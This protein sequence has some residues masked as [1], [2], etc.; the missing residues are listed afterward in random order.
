MKK[1]AGILLYRFVKKELQF[2]LVHPG[3][4]FWKNKDAGAW[5][6][7]KGEYEEDE[8]P[9]EAARREFREETGVVVD[10]HFIELRTARLKSGKQINAWALE[11]DIA[12][13]IQSNT[14]LLEWPPRSGKKIEVPE[15]DKA[16]WCT[17]NEAK[18]KINPAQLVFLD[19][20]VEM[21]ASNNRT[22]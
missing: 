6:I 8:D 3:G 1:S 22:P 7:P 14:F 9:L 17:Y 13:E 12:E 21:M 15:V 2:F 10:G 16:K 18:E 19:R 20:L 5:S 4:P 11:K